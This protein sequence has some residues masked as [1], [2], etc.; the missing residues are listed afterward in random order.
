MAE[1]KSFVGSAEIQQEAGDD[2]I[3]FDKMDISDNFETQ[4]IPFMQMHGL[5]PEGKY[6][7]VHD[8]EEKLTK[9][10]WAEIIAKLATKY[11]V[12]TEDIERIFNISVEEVQQDKEI[13]EMANNVYKSIING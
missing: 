1:D 6:F 4:L 12:S 10:E 8:T 7:L 11:T 3:Y 5:L 13:T 9:L 2:I